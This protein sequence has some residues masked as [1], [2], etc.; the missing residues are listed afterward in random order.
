MQ[1]PNNYADTQVGGDY[2]PVKLG[3]HT[4]IIK[5]V[6]ET[7]SKTGKPMIKVSIDFDKSDV[8]PSYFMNSFKADIRPDKKWPFQAT[9]YILS[10]D[11]SGACS[12]SFKSFITSVEKS[13]NSECVWGDG[14]A[15]WFKNKKVGVVFGEVEEE[16]N[17]EVKLR[18]RI[19]FFCNYESAKNANIPDVKRIQNNSSSDSAPGF[20]SIPAGS[21]EEI[22]F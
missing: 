21:D 19:R 20:M 10:E 16:Y 1:K 8:Q 6:E 4:A 18:R 5:N 12:K 15:D 7:T 9:Q 14:F 2:I 3:G 17:G 13:N 11:N 22:P